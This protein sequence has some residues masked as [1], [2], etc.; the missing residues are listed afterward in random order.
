MVQIRA[1]ANHER[2]SISVPFLSEVMAI[3]SWPNATRPA[4]F[5]PAPCTDTASARRYV[6]ST[7]SPT[8]TPSSRFGFSTWI[9]GPIHTF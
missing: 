5:F 7:R 3:S 4:H 1:T 8:F 6:I 2:F 9:V